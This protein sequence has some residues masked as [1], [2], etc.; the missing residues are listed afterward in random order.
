MRTFRLAAL[1]ALTA[2][3]VV[4]CKQEDHEASRPSRLTLLFTTDEHS[5]L[6][7]F[8]NEGDDWP[9]PAT[10]GDGSLVGGVA[11]RATII[12]AQRTA[13]TQR[14]G[15]S[16][17][18]SSGDFSQGTLA[19]VAFTTSNPDLGLMR[20]LGYDVVAL[21]N[22]EFELGPAAL[23]AAVGGSVSR[24]QAVPL[25]LTNVAFDD[26]SAADDAL[27]A[28]YGERGSGKAIT[29]SR[30]VETV[31]GLRVGF[32]S[33]MGFDAARGAAAAA[34]VSFGHAITQATT[35]TE[36][37]ASA[38]ALIQAEVDSLRAEGVDAVVL[39]GHG[40]V[41]ANPAVPGDDER[42]AGLLEGVDLVLAGHT[43]LQKDLRLIED[44]EQRQVPL[45]AAPP[46]GRAV[47]KVELMVHPGGRP[48][49]VED[50]TELLPVDSTTIPLATAIIAGALTSVVEG[51]EAQFLPATL[52]LIEGA[53]VTDDPAVPGDLYFRPLCHSAFDVI[54]LRQPG[55]TNALNLDT[56]AMLAVMAGIGLPTEVAIQNSGGAR[57]DFFPGDITM[58]DVFRMAP[59]GGDPT[60]GTP[61]YPL[62][63]VYMTAVEL[64]AAFEGTLPMAYPLS[65]IYS[66][67]YFL[68]PAGL[69]IAFDP[70]RPPL[71]PTDPTGPGWVTEMALVAPD[72]TE[73]VLYDA[74]VDYSPTLPPGWTANPLALHSLVSTYYVASFAQYFGL[75]LY[76]D[77]SGTALGSLADAIVEWP[78][79][80]YTVKDHQT[81]GRYLYGT[82]ALNGGELPS[83]YDETTAEGAVPRRV[84][85]ETAVAGACLS[86]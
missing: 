54:G 23:A 62:V 67:D 50:Q 86:L 17:V 68:A 36:F 80:S 66:P 49:L 38:A 25:V 73:T 4:G 13:S 29:R 14:G 76:A 21:G 12:G 57:A 10:A 82:C 24:G 70:T 64:R 19:A 51:I 34:P 2:V 15:D 5:H 39:L 40:G 56:D 58:A 43:H 27:A 33:S 46:L 85:C 16:L 7:A 8:G 84:V 71:D 30:I 63:R 22:H 6:F 44:A 65:P 83:I 3:A 41:S 47:G 69:R 20:A 28:L 45:I 74:S 53:P 61:G 42:L 11:R 26:T 78:G 9:L 31:R 37:L 52:S 1:V 60:T 79:T 18:V 48:T 75:H 72:G 77:A 81:L 35:A 55:E 32:V 59:L